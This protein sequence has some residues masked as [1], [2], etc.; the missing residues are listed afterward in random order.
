MEALERRLA[1]YR[2]Y[3]GPYRDVRAALGE[4]SLLAR[5]LGD[6]LDQAFEL[7]FSLLGVLHDARAMRRAHA[8]LTGVDRRRRAY[9]LELLDQLLTPKERA[10]VN[11]PISVHHRELDGGDPARLAQCLAQLSTS[12]DPVLRVCVAWLKRTLDSEASA[13]K[14]AAM[15]DVTVKRLFAL[16]NVELF[17]QC[18]VDDLA[19]VATVARE[20]SFA[21]GDR[22]YAEGD[23]GDALYVIIEG[24]VEARRDGE[25]V[26]IFGPREVFGELCLFDGAPRLADM[27]VTKPLST[28]VIDRRDFLDLMSERPQLLQGVFRVMSRQ[29]KSVVMELPGRR[30]SQENPIPPDID[31][32]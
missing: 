19:A 8:H 11:E 3:S 9:A 15:S 4:A 1:T 23:P 28:L 5:A 10:L 13:W 22:V 27:M 14:E 26:L 18:D 31:P 2:Q 6:R 25:L 16:E 12:D 20:Q 7:T 32:D 21:L 17:A 24:V 30:L 29:L